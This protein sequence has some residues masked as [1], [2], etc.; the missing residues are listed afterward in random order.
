[1]SDIAEKIASL[2]P[3]KRE[4]LAR[5]LQ[6][7]KRR[8]PATELGGRAMSVEAMTAEAALDPAI[9]PASAVPPAAEPA[10]ILLTGATGFLGAFLL[11]ELLQQTK[12]QICCLVR[13]PNAPEGRQRIL[14]NLE[15]Y[16]LLGD[17]PGD[18]LVPVLGDLA[19]PGL[20]LTPP[21]WPE[22]AEQ[23]DV[24]H[25]CGALVRWTYPYAA[26]RAANVAGTHEVLRLACTRKVK[27]VHFISS[28]GVFSSPHCSRETILETDELEASGPLYMGY[29]QSKW[30]SE[31]MVRL[32]AA[33]GL[34]VTIHRPNTTGS[35][36]T[37]AQ[38]LQDYLFLLL[39][40][41]IELGAAPELDLRIAGAPV[42]FVGQAI[43]RLASRPD[44][45]G[46][47][48]HLVNPNEILWN[49]L[50]GW[51]REAGYPIRL[52]PYAEWVPILQEAVKASRSRTLVSFSPFFT[53]AMLA[54]VR[55]PR[56][57]CQQVVA[58]LAGSG[59]ACPPID[60]ALLT[61]LFGY[62]VGHGHLEP[63]PA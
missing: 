15:A 28:V 50:C 37:G 21:Q 18:R 45:V 38:N 1:M 17:D 59:L 36:Q 34:P 5:R 3:S 25:H 9:D 32:A 7:A 12:A 48:F 24:I 29:A 16:Q 13:A 31:K 58:G 44:S 40:S 4:L 56:F 60:A 33:R 19:Q 35:S 6:Q 62:L 23:I 41:C 2:S 39:K 63:P 61:T 51:L 14:K 27:P 46:R 8:E 49:D 53:E 54:Q 30:I 10:N 47:T 42:D 11:H 20:G 55:L 22:L 26:V 57:D 52:L 43:V